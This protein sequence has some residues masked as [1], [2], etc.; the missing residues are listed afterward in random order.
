M[1]VAHCFQAPGT[2]FLKSTVIFSSNL[3]LF[4]LKRTSSKR[5][6]I[7]HARPEAGLESRSKAGVRGLIF[8]SPE[9]G[10]VNNKLPA[11]GGRPFFITATRGNE[12]KL[13][14]FSKTLCLK[15]SLRSGRETKISY[16]LAQRGSQHCVELFPD[17]VSLNRMNFF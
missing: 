4:R 17:Y 13:N 8:I 11:W 14:L 9:L 15:Q 3:W 6:R 5:K 16:A 7:S 1:A 12:K 10:A 2:S